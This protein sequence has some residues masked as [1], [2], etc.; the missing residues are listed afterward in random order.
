MFLIGYSVFGAG[1]CYATHEIFD[2]KER[3]MAAAEQAVKGRTSVVYFAEVTATVT[4][5]PQWKPAS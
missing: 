4:A 3:A 5:L 2:T 1:S